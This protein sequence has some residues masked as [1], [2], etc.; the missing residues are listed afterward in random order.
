MNEGVPTRDDISATQSAPTA[1]RD[2]S[3]SHIARLL[4][5]PIDTPGGPVYQSQALERRIHP[6]KS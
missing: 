4:Y 6:Q 5:R 3:S 2:V 1:T